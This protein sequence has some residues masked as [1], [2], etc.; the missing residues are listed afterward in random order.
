MARKHTSA[1]TLPAPTHQE[2]A[3]APAPAQEPE[4]PQAHQEPG[5]DVSLLGTHQE[6]G[7]EPEAPQEPAI[8]RDAS[9]RPNP[10]L[11]ECHARWNAPGGWGSKRAGT[12]ES[13]PL[14]GGPGT[15]TATDN[16]SRCYGCNRPF[17][18]KATP[19]VAAD[20]YVW[21]AL[22]ATV[23]D[24]GPGLPQVQVQRTA[25]RVAAPVA[26]AEDAGL[27]AEVARLTALVAQLAGA[28]APEAPQE[29]APEAAP[30]PAA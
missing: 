19:V 16:P 25:A 11:A 12:V 8:L 7:Q 24:G 4:A 15:G 21:H 20:S 23:K 30:E 22:C 5:Q 28:L 17:S 13:G 9:G 14:A 10:F 6:P 18:S 2:P 27:R 29:P 26:S 3:P 1:G